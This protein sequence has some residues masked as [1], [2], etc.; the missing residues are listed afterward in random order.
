MNE[1]RYSKLRIK[2]T[3]GTYSELRSLKY[4]NRIL[5]QNIFNTENALKYAIYFVVHET[6]HS[7]VM[8]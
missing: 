7:P 4:I 2:H 6:A 1:R 5:T 8:D 3:N